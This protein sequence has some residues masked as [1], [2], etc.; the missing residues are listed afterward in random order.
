MKQTFTIKESR[1]LPPHLRPLLHNLYNPQHVPNLFS[2]PPQCSLYTGWLGNE[3]MAAITVDYRDL[4]TTQQIRMTDAA[5]TNFAAL[6]GLI[7]RVLYQF[8]PH[9]GQ[10]TMVSLN[11]QNAKALQRLDSFTAIGFTPHL[12]S[13]VYDLPVL[14]F[15]K[16]TYAQWQLCL[17]H[18]ET[19][20]LWSST[21]NQYARLLPG[22]LPVSA[23]TID[24]CHRN[25]GA[26]HSLRRNGAVV[27]TMYSRIE[28]SRLHIHELHMT[29]DS[30]TTR[31]GLSFLQQ[32]S[33]IR[34]KKIQDVKVTVTSLQP[35]L[36]DALLKQKATQTS[37]S[38]HTFLKELVPYPSVQ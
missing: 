10:K 23:R 9:I 28:F 37:V 19:Y 34:L 29:C 14:P 7:D 25:Q 4:P 8:H 1:E 20:A 21:R 13:T 2:F 26:F 27:G 3:L 36:R 32:S 17:E 24:E 33:F 18:P 31:E 15:Q 30:F 35:S 16:E 22:A 38:T 12:E 5:Y 6:R 11:V